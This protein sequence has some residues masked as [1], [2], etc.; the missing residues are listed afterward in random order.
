M[1][2]I[3]SHENIITEAMIELSE[4]PMASFLKYA[5]LGFMVH[6]ASL[7][8]WVPRCSREIVPTTGCA[9]FSIELGIASAKKECCLHPYTKN[10]LQKRTH[11]QQ[12]FIHL[13]RAAF[14]VQDTLVL[15]T[16]VAITEFERLVRAHRSQH[17]QIQKIYN[18]LNFE[19]TCVFCYPSVVFQKSTPHLTLFFHISG[20]AGFA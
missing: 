8:K 20:C 13:R 6:L 16:F 14:P 15:K 12:C 2:R 5:T 11:T 4:S 19:L 3:F 17:P 10:N 9:T 18:L 7:A 1:F